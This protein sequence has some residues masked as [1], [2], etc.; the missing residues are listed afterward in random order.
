MV[1]PQGINWTTITVQLL[2]S[3]PLIIGA[4]A[5]AVALLRRQ[6]TA[7]HAE[8]VKSVNGMKDELVAAATAKAAAEATVVE[9]MA[10]QAREDAHRGSADDRKTL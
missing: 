2:V 1:D 4:L 5:A 6:L 3:M 10:Q 7:N 9:K 8:V